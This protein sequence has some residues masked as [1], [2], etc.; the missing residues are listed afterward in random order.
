[1]LP[2]G[3]VW[4]EADGE[5]CFHPDEAVTGVLRA[6]FE[7]FAVHG[8]VRATWLWL[9]AQRLRWALQKVAYTR[10]GPGS[11]RSPGWSLRT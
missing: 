9:R 6:V 11:R 3:L 8:S 1:V 2:V 4:G 5:V 7:Q 10:R